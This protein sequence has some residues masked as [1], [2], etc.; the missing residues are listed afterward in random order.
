MILLDTSETLAAVRRSLEAHV[1]PELEDDFARV[2]VLAALRALDELGHRIENGDPC[3]AMNR[4]IDASV[5]AVAEEAR[6]EAPEFAANLN[7]A[8]DVAP[9]AASPRERAREVGDALWRLVSD[10]EEPA[11]ARVFEVLRDEAI[12]T[13]AEDREWMC[14]EAIASLV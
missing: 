5:R 6:A 7:A 8:L 1:L 3:D 4:N 2:Q 9:A 13:T 11:A 12:R 14:D 10:S